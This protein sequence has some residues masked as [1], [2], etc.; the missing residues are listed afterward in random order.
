[1]GAYVNPEKESKEE[2]KTKRLTLEALYNK[3]TKEQQSLYT[4]M[5]GDVLSRRSNESIDIAIRQC[6]NTVCDNKTDCDKCSFKL[7]CA[8]KN[9][10]EGGDD[11]K[12]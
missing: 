11:G 4:R 2:Q 12:S 10:P 6:G 7:E 3:L 1:M 5:Y 9:I 8:L